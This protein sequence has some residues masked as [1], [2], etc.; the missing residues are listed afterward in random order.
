MANKKRESYIL[1]DKPLNLEN[2]QYDNESSSDSSIEPIDLRTPKTK[3]LAFSNINTPQNRQVAIQKSLSAHQ[4]MV[5][6][7]SQMR[8]KL[9]QTSVMSITDDL[10]IIS[11]H[12]ADDMRVC[13]G[14]CNIYNMLYIICF[15]H[16]FMS[17][18][19]LCIGFILFD[20]E[21]IVKHQLLIKEQKQLIIFIFYIIFGLLRFITFGMGVY[22]IPKF[23][24]ENLAILHDKLYRFY[25]CLVKIW[26]GLL[27]LSPLLYDILLLIE[28][29]DDMEIENENGIENGNDN[30]NGVD[31]TMIFILVIFVMELLSS[32]YFFFVIHGFIAIKWPSH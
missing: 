26:L 32:I 8:L 12:Y 18:P 25:K 7:Q 30:G 10:C 1:E 14:C 16:L 3:R 5:R 27:L 4:E 13:F 23:Q 2:K 21:F 19:L 22:L 28:Y 31:N 17:I 20:I 11:T 15:Y 29:I 6:I 24:Y 9:R